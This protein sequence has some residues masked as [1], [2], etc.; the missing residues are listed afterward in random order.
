MLCFAHFFLLEFSLEILSVRLSIAQVESSPVT[1]L[2]LKL[3][4][5]PLRVD[6]KS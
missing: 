6:V 3:L 1:N 4:V 5:R 2:I